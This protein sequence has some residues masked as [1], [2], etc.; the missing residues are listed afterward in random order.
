MC[1]H[2]L[3]H[4]FLLSILFI[5]NFQSSHPVHL[6]LLFLPSRSSAILNFLTFFFTCHLPPNFSSPS[7]VTQTLLHLEQHIKAESTKQTLPPSSLHPRTD[8]TSNSKI[9]DLCT[10]DKPI[11]LPKQPEIHKQTRKI[12]EITILFSWSGFG[13]LELPK[14]QSSASLAFWALT[15][16]LCCHWSLRQA[17][18]SVGVML[19][20]ER[21]K[22]GLVWLAIGSHIFGLPHWQCNANASYATIA[23]IIRQHLWST[24]IFCIW[25]QALRKVE[26]P[27]PA[28]SVL[29]HAEAVSHE[30]NQTV[31]FRN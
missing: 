31:T 23:D 21:N 17:Q 12:A 29:T 5:G 26:R 13:V 1:S 3:F 25:C 15:P 22:E 11:W 30:K 28:V 9:M 18:P 20:R 10:V 7:S 19:S 4:V 24:N 14:L 27:G 2:F 8:S 16:K 6:C